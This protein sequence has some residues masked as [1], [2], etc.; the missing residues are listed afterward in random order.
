MK[1]VLSVGAITIPKQAATYNDRNLSLMKLISGCHLGLS[2]VLHR[3]HHF[4]LD[5]CSHRVSRRV[6]QLSMPS[7]SQKHQ[8]IKNEKSRFIVAP[9]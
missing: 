9:F 4:T 3:F 2:A 5:A 1:A 6:S 7:L 8:V